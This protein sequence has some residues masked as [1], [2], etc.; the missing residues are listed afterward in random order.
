MVCYANAGGNANAR[1]TARAKHYVLFDRPEDLSAKLRPRHKL[2]WTTVNGHDALP[3]SVA[4]RLILQLMAEQDHRDVQVF[5]EFPSDALLARLWGAVVPFLDIEADCIITEAARAAKAVEDHTPFLCQDGDWVEVEGD[6]D[7]WEGNSRWVDCIT[8]GDVFGDTPGGACGLAGAELIYYM[9]PYMLEEFRADDS[10]FAACAQ[11]VGKLFQSDD[12][13][14]VCDG[15]QLASEIGVGLKNTEWHTLLLHTPAGNDATPDGANRGGL[16][17]T[18]L[19]NRVG[20]AEAR[21]ITDSNVTKYVMPSLPRA[22]QHKRKLPSLSRIFSDVESGKDIAEGLTELGEAV[23]VPNPQRIDHRRLMELDSLLAPIFAT[24]NL[25]SDS[26]LHDR[27]AVV[28][29]K[30]DT[31]KVKAKG[32][33]LSATTAASLDKEKT[34]ASGTVLLAQLT[35][36]DAVF[37]LERLRKYIA[38]PDHDPI[39]YLEMAHSGRL[40]PEMRA[41]LVVEAYGL[42]GSAKRDALV[43]IDVDDKR[44]PIPAL[45][46]LAWG[47]FKALE[48]FPDLQHVYDLGQTHMPDVLGRLCARAYSADGTSIPPAL[49]F[50]RAVKMYEALKGRA[51]EKH[52]DFINDGDAVMLA[53]IEGGQGT[54]VTRVAPDALYTDIS[55]VARVRRI[56][57]NVLAFFGLHD[58]PTKSWRQLVASCEHAFMGIP[59]SDSVKRARLGKAM[60]RLI[61]RSLGDIGKRIDLVRYSSK[62]DA[63]GPSC[64]MPIGRGGPA[65]EFAEAMARI[66]DD[67]KRKRSHVADDLSAMSDVVLP[68]ETV[69]A[70]PAAATKRVKAAVFNYG[71]LFDDV[72]DEAPAV[73]TVTTTRAKEVSTEYNTALKLVLKPG[74]MKNKGTVIIHVNAKGA[75]RWLA[76][77]GVPHACLGFQYGH[78]C[79]KARRWKSCTFSEKADHTEDPSGPHKIVDGWA[80]AASQF[81]LPADRKLL[82]A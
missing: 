30:I 7:D 60:Q 16:R 1:R 2:G 39:A 79:V 47:H 76:D 9:G 12:D 69:K 50:A 81:V 38:S 67:Q 58:S 59:A 82:S 80:A 18:D 17:I 46:Q 6:M 63:K 78:V 49:R 61:T 33:N 5:A 51:W 21:A 31:T 13:E 10:H 48:G 55:Q 37:Q 40:T 54:E 4:A 32:A 36:P 75:L 27:I 70:A 15:P 68:S 43:A 29:E 35:Q 44:A 71:D 42:S 28:V 57:T 24:I 56:G 66:H 25:G 8:R 62:L 53:Y 41:T 65:D 20:Y 64:L 73:P 26:V 23:Q 45:M 14:S 3:F 34:T 77:H 72:P 52:L 74:E 22:M 19:R 11:V